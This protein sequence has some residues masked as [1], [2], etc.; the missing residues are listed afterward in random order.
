[1]QV[2]PAWTRTRKNWR[3]GASSRSVPPGREYGLDGC[4]AFVRERRGR[5]GQID[6]RPV[7]GDV[8]GIR[9]PCGYPRQHVSRCRRYS[10]AERATV[11]PVNCR[12][13]IGRDENA[14]CPPRRPRDQLVDRSSRYRVADEV[15]AIGHRIQ[16]AG[17]RHSQTRQDGNGTS[18]RV[19]RLWWTQVAP[20]EAAPRLEQ[21]TP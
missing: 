21:S 10:S 6:V 11:R 13:V 7:G 17:Y 18:A 8:G 3:P 14:K 2:G 9:S 1:M 20:I 4:R 12:C 5:R 19:S 15:D 16:G